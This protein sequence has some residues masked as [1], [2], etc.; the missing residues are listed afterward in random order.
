MRGCLCRGPS[1]RIHCCIF[2]SLVFTRKGGRGP[3]ESCDGSCSW[4][5]GGGVLAHQSAFYR[6]MVHIFQ[7]ARKP[8]IWLFIHF[9][10]FLLLVLFFLAMH[11]NSSR[12]LCDWEGA[13]NPIL[14]NLHALTRPENIINL[15]HF[16]PTNYFQSK[17]SQ[18]HSCAVQSSA[19][20]ILDH[21]PML[22]A[23]IFHGL[24][25]NPTPIKYIHD[26]LFIIYQF[27]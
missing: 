6:M 25:I 17:E 16:L 21:Q 14:V 9:P 24:I 5:R 1:H 10:F 15:W 4:G 22:L 8:R 19:I 12:I 23:A 2:L 13:G 27:F 26:F 20:A 3:F 11:W 18:L 7:A